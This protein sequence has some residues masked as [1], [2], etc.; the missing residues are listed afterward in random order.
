MLAYRRV[1]PCRCDRSENER[2]LG[3]PTFLILVTGA[4]VVVT[5]KENR[6]PATTVALELLV[7]PMHRLEVLVQG[8][9]VVVGV[10]AEV[11]VALGLVDAPPTR[12][13][14]TK[15]PTTTTAAKDVISRID[16]RF[17]PPLAGSAMTSDRTGN[18]SHHSGS[19]N[20]H[21]SPAASPLL[22]RVIGRCGVCVRRVTVTG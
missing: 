9:V 7:N 2:P 20:P 4:P 21:W 12:K 13:P 5:V 6:E 1:W 11:G 14:A 8:R 18:P 15:T 17:R 16:E 19:L 10:E 22:S 3:A